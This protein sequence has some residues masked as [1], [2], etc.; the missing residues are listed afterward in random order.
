[1]KNAMKIV[2]L[3][4]GFSAFAQMPVTN[5]FLADVE[6]KNNLVK[7]E[8]AID[9]TNQTGYNS[10]PSF[11]PDGKSILYSSENVATKKVHICSYD[12]KS[13][14]TRKITATKTSEYSPMLAPDG[15][16]ISS[17]VVEEDSTQRIWLFDKT[18]PETKRCLA[19]KTDSVG[20]Y[21][22]LGKDSILYDKL[23]SPH[24]LHALDLKT[25]E[26]NW[27]CDNPTRSFKQIDAITFFYVIHEE[28]QNLIFFFDIRTKKATLFAKDDVSSQDYVWQPDLGM[29]KSEE[30][31]LYHYVPDT[32][33]WA[34]VVDFSD[35]KITN[36]TRFAFS[37]DKKKLA[38][39]STVTGN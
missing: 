16:N 1:M 36:I 35:F 9:I 13:R 2:I 25:G 27:L 34:K 11:T 23:T 5:I 28:K 6:V 21:A 20:Y 15:Q 38:V 8:K 17:V 24:S 18:K 39:V 26:D 22:W 14:K 7:V 30:N 37:P 12:I 31:K 33:V 29:L 19:E 32:K 3:L 10:Q 4:V